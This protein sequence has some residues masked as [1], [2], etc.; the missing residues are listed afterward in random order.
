MSYLQTGLEVRRWCF[1]LR[2]NDIYKSI[3]RSVVMPV[4]LQRDRDQRKEER[5]VTANETLDHV[6]LLLENK[7][8]YKLLSR[9]F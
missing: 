5:S 7:R 1:T 9:E 4:L 3:H 8:T 2:Q 6:L